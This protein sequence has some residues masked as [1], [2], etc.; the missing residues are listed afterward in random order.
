VIANTVLKNVDRFTKLN[1]KMAQEARRLG[2]MIGNSTE[3]EF[4][5]MVHEKNNA[6]SHV[7]VRTV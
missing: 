6:N 2:G 3:R 7:T 5:G 4:N 1:I